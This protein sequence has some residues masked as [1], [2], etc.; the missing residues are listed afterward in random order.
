MRKSLFA[1]LLLCP[2][3]FA[4]TPHWEYGGEAGPAKWASLTPEYGQCAGSNQSPVNLTG[5]VEAELA[6]L[7]FHYQAGG[8]SVTNNGH[9]VQVD[10]APGSTLEL[11]GMRF[12]LK[13]F[14]FHA[15]SENLI[16]GKSYPLEGHLVH[17]N[18][19]G[20]LA[21]VAVMFEPGGANPALGQALQSLPA[22]AGEHHELKEPVSAER[23]LPAKRDYYRFS[24]SLTT[25]PCSE[26]VRW[27]VMKDPVQVSQAQI[28]A[29]KAVM[30]HP[31]N[32]PVQPLNGRLV[33][34]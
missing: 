11:D 28:D 7:Q 4:A 5:L 9:T 16:E 22:K 34:Q 29:F 23:L 8:H 13:Q 33:L 14:H 24:G 3:A 18:D 25:P 26:G 1:A 27:L 20:E 6:P 10:Y 15:P 30:H 19:Q 21:V 31:N 2:T 17:A 12:A 32:R